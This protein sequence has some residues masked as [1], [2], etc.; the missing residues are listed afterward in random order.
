MVTLEELVVVAQAAIELTGI[1]RL[2][3][4]TPLAKQL[5]L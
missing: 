1:V 2:L 4:V 3:E 5:F